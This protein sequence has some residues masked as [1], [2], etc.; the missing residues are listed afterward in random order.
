M[1]RD[2]EEE[3]ALKGEGAGLVYGFRR[4][5]SKLYI[6]E[7]PLTKPFLNP[8]CKVCILHHTLRTQEKKK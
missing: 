8:C 1:H 3:Q 4:V 2:T 6:T 7:K 5:E